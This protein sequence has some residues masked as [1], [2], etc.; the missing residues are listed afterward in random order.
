MI[1]E[2]IGEFIGG[3]AMGYALF[4]IPVKHVY[5]WYKYGTN[6][7]IKINTDDDEYEARKILDDY[8]EKNPEGRIFI[9]NKRVLFLGD[10]KPL[11]VKIWKE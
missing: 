5:P 9:N 11:F 10:K 1:L 4:D 2:F 7:V 8:H 6:G 3:M